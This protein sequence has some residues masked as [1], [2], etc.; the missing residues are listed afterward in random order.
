MNTSGWDRV[1]CNFSVRAT[2]TCMV[3]LNFESGG[4]GMVIE[5]TATAARQIA[6]ALI[7]AADEA[8]PSAPP[9]TEE[10]A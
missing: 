9:P 2:S 3:V 4:E 8:F 10:Q 1:G 6:A 5:V 7:M